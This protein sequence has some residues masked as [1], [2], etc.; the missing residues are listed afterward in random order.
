MSITG[1]G[2]ITAANLLAQNNVNN[3]LNTLS[4]ELGTGQAAQTYSGLGSQAGVALA[5]S[6]QLSAITGYSNAAST[7]G[8]T[9]S[10]AQSTLTQL[11]STGDAVEQSINQQ[12][13]FTLNNNGQTTTQAAAITQLDSIL[14]LLNT[15]VGDN[16]I[17]SGSAV[18][19]QSVA[20]TSAILN[21][22][23][24]QAG[25]TQV[26]ANRLQADQGADVPPLGRLVIP[27]ASGS[28]VSVAEDA[29][30]PFG[31]KLA[32]VNSTLTGATVTGPSGTPASISVDLGSNPNAGDSIQFGFT[33]PDGS[34]QTITLTATTASPPGANQF[35]IGTTAADTATNLQAALTS[36]VSSLAQTALPAASAMAAANNFFTSDPPQVVDP[37]QPPDYAT[38]TALVNGTTANTVFWYTGENG[39]TPARQTATAQVGP[40][41]TISYGMRANEQAI[42]TLVANVAVLA[43][44]TYSASNTNAQASY[45]AL[46]QDVATNLDGKSGTQSI[47]DIEA[48]LA[49]AQTTVKNATTLNTQTQTTLQDMMQNIDGVNQNAVGEQI[50]TLQN[51]LSASLSVTARL[52]QLSLVNYLAASTG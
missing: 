10:I 30:S 46:T 44:T 52:A 29:V 9:L 11:E 2:S 1:P 42:S 14:S 47:D 27:A 36:A 12:P 23:G 13:A 19:Q 43:A 17:F 21:G 49:N 34:S 45:Q 35:T 18:N 40:S 32:S 41:T 31:F 24:A 5:L 4:E 33:L 26:I 38:A 48:D 28:T 50:L 25:L 16:Y 3:Q 39:N 20:S 8:T 6:A 51:T 22:D 37:G 7:V 15:Q